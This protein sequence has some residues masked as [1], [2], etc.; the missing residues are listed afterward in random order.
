MIK[1]TVEHVNCFPYTGPNIWNMSVSI[2]RKQIAFGSQDGSLSIISIDGAPRTDYPPV[3]ENNMMHHSYFSPDSK[4]ILTGGGDRN[5]VIRDADDDAAQRASTFQTWVYINKM[6]PKERAV[7]HLPKHVVDVIL[8]YNRMP[9]PSRVIEAPKTVHFFGISRDCKTIVVSDYQY[10]IT[11][12][13]FDTGK[14]KRTFS[15]AMYIGALVIVDDVADKILVASKGVFMLEP[16]A[17]DAYA[18]EPTLQYYHESDYVDH[19]VLTSDRK[20]F[21]CA[22]V[23]G[24]IHLWDIESCKFLGLIRRVE[25]IVYLKILPGDAALLIADNRHIWIEHVDGS[26]A[27]AVFPRSAGAFSTLGVSTHG[28]DV[29]VVLAYKY[30]ISS[31]FTYNIRVYRVT[32]KTEQTL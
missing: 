12:L 13:D 22:D 28:N 24:D 14:V 7:P 11:T 6:Q 26:G 32:H 27:T 19:L 2:K 17:T 10:S 21:I 15:G 20:R 5:I 29:L 23:S 8:K 16:H 25:N 4:Y 9:V 18:L 31:L 3:A 30:I 1:Y